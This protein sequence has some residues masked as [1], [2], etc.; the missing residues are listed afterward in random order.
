VLVNI[1]INDIDYGTEYTLS[2]FAGDTKLSGTVGATERRDFIQR[3][4]DRLEKWAHMNLMRFNKVKYMVLHMGQGD[5]RHMY[6]L[7]KDLTESRPPEKDLGVL[8]NGKPNMYQQ[9]VLAA[10]KTNGIL[11]CI[12]RSLASRVRK[13]IVPFYSNFVRPHLE[14]C[15]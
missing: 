10:Q 12:K 2:E 14:D 9:C 5:P 7:G 8:V 13:V 3:D 15:V 6:R 4:L 11:D 1:F